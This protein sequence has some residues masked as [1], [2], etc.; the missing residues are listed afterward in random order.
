MTIEGFDSEPYPRSVVVQGGVTYFLGR[1]LDGARRLG[2]VGGGDF[3]GEENG[4]RVKVC[5]CTLA[6]FAAS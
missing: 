5:P 1:G 3:A 6:P 2:I 4:Q